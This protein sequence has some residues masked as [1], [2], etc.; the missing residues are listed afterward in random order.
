LP[1]ISSLNNNQIQQAIT[2]IVNDVEQ[3]QQ[4][5][6]PPPKTVIPCGFRSAANSSSQQQQQMNV[7]A[8]RPPSTIPPAHKFM[9]SARN[10]VYTQEEL[11]RLSQTS[12]TMP[13]MVSDDTKCLFVPKVCLF[14]VG[15]FLSFFLF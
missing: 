9:P 11:K 7:T 13:G 3:Q 15:S 4:Q 2:T 5:N 8:Q 1:T 10:V 14:V 6:L 12:A